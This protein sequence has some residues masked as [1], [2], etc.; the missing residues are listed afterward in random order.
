M[1][2]LLTSQHFKNLNLLNQLC[3]KHF[4][5]VTTYVISVTDNDPYIRKAMVAI[6]PQ[7]WYEWL[8]SSIVG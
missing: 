5:A 7:A 2:N 8:N 3:V 1:P 6:T 4:Y